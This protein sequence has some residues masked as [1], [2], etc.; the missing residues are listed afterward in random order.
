MVARLAP[1]PL[2]TS[3]VDVDVTAPV[4]SV[5]AGYV[6]AVPYFFSCIATARE[7]RI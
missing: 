1:E 7:E 2:E 3:A 5:C 6:W 4:G